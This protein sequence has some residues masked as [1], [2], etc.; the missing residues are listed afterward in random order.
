MGYSI[1]DM[2]QQI[3]YVDEDAWIRKKFEQEL[4][5]NGLTSLMPEEAYRDTAFKFDDEEM[6][7][8]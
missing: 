3:E 5:K 7:G 4:A 6:Q 2:R 8:D 1:R